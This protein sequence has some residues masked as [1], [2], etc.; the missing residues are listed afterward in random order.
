ML[1]AEEA[2]ARLDW[3]HEGKKGVGL[4]KHNMES[5]RSAVKLSLT[6]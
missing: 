5:S 4:E 2:A 3:T 6:D 1:P